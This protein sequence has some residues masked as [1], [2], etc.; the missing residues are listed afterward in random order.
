M[1]CCQSHI[2]MSMDG[3]PSMLNLVWNVQKSDFANETPPP[4][5]VFIA[6]EGWFDNLG[7][8]GQLGPN[9]QPPSTEREIPIVLQWEVL[10]NKTINCSNGNICNSKHSY[11]RNGDRGGYTCH[12][13]ETYHGNP[14]E[15]C[16]GGPKFVA[17]G[18]KW[19]QL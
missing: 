4:T 3:M 7:F 2:S 8:S 19:L 6:E 5:Y 18:Q 11:C 16:K 17:I 12:C 13:K 9:L 1:G 10:S 14:Y 15:G